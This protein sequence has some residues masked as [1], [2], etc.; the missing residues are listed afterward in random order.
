MDLGGHSSAHN[1]TPHLV[2]CLTFPTNTLPSVRWSR[3][4]QLPASRPT[5]R[6]RV[7]CG[8]DQPPCWASCGQAPLC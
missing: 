3:P 6:L 1:N 5:A 8:V 7:W 4:F 2:S